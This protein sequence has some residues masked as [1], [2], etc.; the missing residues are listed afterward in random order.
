MQY[1]RPLICFS[2][3]I[4][5]LLGLSAS[6]H[7]QD[8]PFNLITSPLPID[9]TTKPG[10]S[11]S[12]EL[13]V[14][15]NSSQP[16]RLQVTLYKFSVDSNSEVTLSEQE[17]G[18]NFMDWVSFSPRVFTAD[19][20]QWETVKMDVDVPSDAAL[21]Y[22][23]A[24]G[25]SRASQP[26][27]VP[28]GAALRGQVV[29]FVLLDVDVPG[30]KRQLEVTEFSAD[31][32]TYEFLPAT[33]I[34]K[35]RNTGNI[36][37]VPAGTIFVKRGDNTVATLAVNPGQGNVLPNSTR[38]FTATWADGFPLYV[39][40]TDEAGQAVSNEDSTTATTLKWDFGEVTKLRIGK[41]SAQLL[42]VYDDGQRDVPIEGNLS[43]WVMPWRVMGVF[44][45]V[46]TLV[47]IG[48]WS[49]GRKVFGVGKK[50]KRP[51]RDTPP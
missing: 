3:I 41:Y 38:T 45:V 35:V 33:F 11:V 42:L 49:V 32:S 12:A 15:N 50:I 29:T 37:V 36:H 16:E 10:Q 48:L 8:Q 44:L 26:A 47:S 30:A 19:P 31:K 6:S 4:L 22:Y 9:L 14:K 5:A 27:P 18:D 43:F 34:V 1:I 7:A 21:G 40:K 28:S 24:V 13:R 25:F 23:Y 39:P 17:P 46:L 51:K 20:N 2:A